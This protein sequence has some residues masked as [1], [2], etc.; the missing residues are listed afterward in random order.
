MYIHGKNA[1]FVKPEET[2]ASMGKRWPTITV[3]I[4]SYNQGVYLEKCVESIFRQNYPCLECIVVDLGSTDNSLQIIHKYKE[5]FKCCIDKSCTNQYEAINEG[6]SESSGEIMAWLNA[7]EI[8]Y[9]YSLFKIASLFMAYPVVEWISGLSTVT[10]AD[11]GIVHVSP[12]ISWTRARILNLDFA[13]RQVFINQETVF[14]KRSLW[15]K[16]GGYFDKRFSYAADYELW[17]RFSRFSHLFTVPDI[18]ASRKIV[19]YQESIKGK[20][21]YYEEM[22]Q[23]VERE[24]KLSK[25]ISFC[26]SKETSHFLSPIYRSTFPVHKELSSKPKDF[27]ITTDKAFAKTPSIQKHFLHKWMQQVELLGEDYGAWKKDK[28]LPFEFVSFL[29][30]SDKIEGVFFD[31][32]DTFVYRLSDDHCHLFIEVARRLRSLGLIKEDLS[33]ME[34][35]AL[36]ILAEDKARNLFVKHFGSCECSIEDVYRQMQAVLVDTK[37]AAKVELETERD[38][39]FLNPAIQSLALYLKSCGKK[40]GILSDTCFSGSQIASILQHNGFPVEKLDLILTSSDVKVSKKSGKLFEEALFRLNGNP[41]K[42]VH[43]GSNVEAD[44]QGAK[45]AGVKGKYYPKY[46]PNQNHIV[47]RETVLNARS[48][49]T[50]S[51]N[52]FRFLVANWSGHINEKWR[53]FFEVG[54]LIWGPPIARY[55]D[56]CIEQCR[57]FNITTVLAFMREAHTLLPVFNKAAEVYEFGVRA[58]PFFVSR[59]AINMASLFNIS[60]ETLIKGITN[61]RPE[62]VTPRWIFDVFELPYHFAKKFLSHYSMDKILDHEEI[63]SLVDSIMRIPECRMLLEKKSLEKRER[64]LKYMKQC[65]NDCS[66]FAI[67]DIGYNAT[68]QGIIDDILRYNRMNTRTVGLYFATTHNA[69]RKILSGSIIRSYTGD[70]GGD[71]SYIKSFMTC[72]KILEQSLNSVSGQT[73]GYVLT[74]KGTVMPV[75]ENLILP[76][77]QIVSRYFIQ[78]GIIEFCSLW[79]SVMSRIVK[80]KEPTFQEKE[81]WQSEIDYHCKNIIRRISCFPLK[82]EAICLGKLFLDDSGERK[83]VIGDY[84]R[85][86]YRDKGMSFFQQNKVNWPAGIIAL[87]T[88]E[89][90]DGIFR[91][92]KLFL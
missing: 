19:G 48:D 56:W 29:I 69:G 70:L 45:K 10:N 36:R 5:N 12:P 63:C 2:G 76:H 52:A 71:F 46:Y 73:L 80:Q 4:L 86:M 24:M 20:K 67:I 9:D 64:F 1:T 42:W 13:F 74:N 78:R 11:D 72:S 17:V 41:V 26:N 37:K 49:W 22:V 30:N 82:E 43:I 84:E 53:V 27:F 65:V 85:M 47:F 6:F 31:F 32:F 91:Y 7:D 39:C 90:I 77:D 58:V 21:R 50:V 83:Y 68:I 62:V 51:P 75:T 34:F 79:F 15:E 88:P 28:R 60:L 89:I 81:T 54:A 3:V 92:E 25:N 66:T 57:K 33:D 87:E 38:F 18:L 44:V 14:W 16:A 35:Y 40:V 8:Y 59:R 55:I 61:L 23:I